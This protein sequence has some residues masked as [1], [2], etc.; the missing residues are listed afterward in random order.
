MVV[1][2]LSTDSVGEAVGWAV[3]LDEDAV[4]LDADEIEEDLASS[5]SSS[6]A[7]FVLIPDGQND[8]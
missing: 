3:L 4:A 7:M 1:P 5:G 2:A 6:L 8:Q